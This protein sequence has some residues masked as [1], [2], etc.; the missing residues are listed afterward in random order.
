MSKPVCQL[1]DCDGNAFVLIG[2]AAAREVA[3]E[4][5]RRA[6]I[7]RR[8]QYCDRDPTAGLRAHR[9]GAA[10]R[11]IAEARQIRAWFTPLP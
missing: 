10:R 2:R 3:A 11:L 1:T 7:A 6:A 5:L 8:T 4:C 9:L